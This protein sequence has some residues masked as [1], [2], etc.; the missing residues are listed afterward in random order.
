MQGIVYAATPISE[1]GAGA[2]ILNMSLGA[3]IDTKDKESKGLLKAMQKAVQYATKRGV[4]V[5]SAAGNDAVDLQHTKLVSVPA[6]S[7]SSIAVSAT[8][9]VGFA[10]G[11]TNFDRPAS[12]TNFGQSAINVSAPGGDFAYPTDEAC[13]LPTTNGAPVTTACWVFDMVISTNVGGWAWAAGTSM[14]A[15]AA[16]AV[17]AIIKAKNPGI[18]FGAWKNAL[19]QTALDRGKPGNDAYHGK[20]WVNALAACRQ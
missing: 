2:D 3:L 1:G 18:S 17:A 7:G 14:A 19:A 16:S 20:G 8:G 11:A 9:P 5:V 15:P 13:T 6:E 10:Y 12:Y 4:L